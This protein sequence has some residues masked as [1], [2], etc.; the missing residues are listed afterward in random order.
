[1][2]HR[3]Q[4]RDQVLSWLGDEVV[5]GVALGSPPDHVFGEP[6]SE[7]DG[8]VFDESNTADAPYAHKLFPWDEVQ[9]LIDYEYNAGFGG[10]GCHPIYL[11]TPTR[12]LYIHEYDGSTSLSTIPRHPVDGRVGFG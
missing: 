6:K 1:M 4:F 5:D 10:A 11:W 2:W 3:K 7:F 9:K 8:V 12:I